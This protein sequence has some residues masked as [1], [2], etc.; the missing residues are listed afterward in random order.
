MTSGTK[1]S[2]RGR[3]M[4]EAMFLGA[5]LGRPCNGLKRGHLQQLLGAPIEGFLDGRIL[6]PNRPE[7]NVLPGLHGA[8]GTMVFASLAMCEEDGAGRSPAAQVGARLLELSGE[9]DQ[10]SVV[11]RSPGRPLRDALARWRNEY[12]WEESDFFAREEPRE[13][14]G[15]ATFA[16]VPSAI[17]MQ[18]APGVAARLAR[19]T[20]TKLAPVAAAYCVARTAELICN[21]G[22]KIDSSAILKQL[23]PAV[24]E[25][26]ATFIEQHSTEW[27][28]LGWNGKPPTLSCTLEPLAALLREEND[29][30]AEKTIVAGAA[31]M[32]PVCAVTHVQHGF[33]GASIPWLVYRALGTLSPR[34]AIEDALNRGG[35]TGAV[36]SLL[37]ALLV[38]RHDRQFLPDEWY[39][40]TLALPLLYRCLDDPG[41]ANGIIAAEQR[42]SAMEDALRDPLRKEL[43]R[44]EA[45]D[46]AAGRPRKKSHLEEDQEEAKFAPP[47]HLWLKPGEEEDPEKKRIL[48]EA[49][50]KRRIDWKESRRKDER[51]RR[52]D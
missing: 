5:A 3:A 50:G 45:A 29:S 37:A 7:R 46:A 22:K 25:F 21:A 8:A 11:F 4:L 47:P 40:G 28:E 10:E 19:L 17:G 51:E 34:N 38:C 15:A 44:Q 52:R 27:E 23:I 30:L 26:E 42:W 14:I 48:K 9:E 20:H 36:V 24:R 6:F 43:R 13:G 41:G 49:R 16:L 35:E 1:P 2:A 18:Q 39:A 32:N 33:V 31:E 12:P